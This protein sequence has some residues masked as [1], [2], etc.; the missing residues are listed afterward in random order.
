ML[1]EWVQSI[2]RFPESREMEI[3]IMDAGLLPE[4]V[5]RLQNMGCKVVA[6]EWPCPIPPSKIRGRNFLKSCVCRPF[7]PEYFPGYD[8]YFWMDADT[9]V[10][11]WDVVGMFLEGARRGK[12]ALTAQVDR[13]YPRPIRIKWL[14]PF[15]W[16]VRGFYYSNARK[17][18]GCKMARELL[19]YYVLSAGAFALRADAPHWKAWQN[20]IKTTLQRGGNIF[21]AEQLSLG[22]ICH[23]EGLPVESLPA[24]THWLCQFKPLW[25]EQA[26]AFVE[27]NMPHEKIG[28][29]H[30]S[31][32]DKMRVD[33]SLTTDFKTL[34]GQTVELSYRYPHFDGEAAEEPVS[35][36][37]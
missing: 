17:A 28:I 12:M 23:L 24:W 33:R 36:V 3:G 5:L 4:Q 26:H 8:M 19:N 22:I 29:L 31:G 27:P 21:T 14:G 30:L 20:R 15:P 35:V 16:K 11:R 37:A 32:W 18:Y 6:P 2:R 10:Q 1:L 25:D 34:E 7:I 9:W 13:A